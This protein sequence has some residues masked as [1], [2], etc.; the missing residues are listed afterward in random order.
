[1]SRSSEGLSTE[2]KA[3]MEGTPAQWM[4]S[5]KDVLD[6]SFLACRKASLRHLFAGTFESSLMVLKIS[7]PPGGWAGGL[8]DLFPV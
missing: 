8:R 6:K 1:M 2:I 5:K 7:E 3:L 4:S